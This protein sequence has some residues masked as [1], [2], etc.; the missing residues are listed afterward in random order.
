MISRENYSVSNIYSVAISPSEKNV[1]YILSENGLDVTRDGGET[2]EKIETLLK[3]GEVVAHKIVVDPNNK[4]ILYLVDGK[5][6]YKTYNGGETWAPTPLKISWPVKSFVIDSTNSN[7]IYMGLAA[8]PKEP[9]FLL[10]F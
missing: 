4:N 7:N 6:L 1:F 10:P 3:D 8:P 9:F 5:I 2:F